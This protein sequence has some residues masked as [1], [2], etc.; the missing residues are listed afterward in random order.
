MV[1]NLKT[2]GPQA[3]SMLVENGDAVYIGRHYKGVFGHWKKS[4]WM[5]P[6]R[7]QRDGSISGRMK[8]VERYEQ[9]VRASP[10]LMKSLHE[11]EGKVL[12]CWCAP[13]PCHG[14]V[15]VKLIE[16]AKERRI[17]HGEVPKGKAN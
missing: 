10:L 1:A 8:V 15:L 14:D 5:N 4:K 12:F 11:L 2:W 6:F 3:A 17:A 9:Y 13:K 16:E 7:S